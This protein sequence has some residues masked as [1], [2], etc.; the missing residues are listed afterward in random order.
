MKRNYLIY[1]LTITFLGSCAT[2]RTTTIVSCDYDTKLNQTNYMVFPYGAVSLPNKWEKTNY[3]SSARQQFFK[4]EEGVTIAISFAPSNKYE[5][6][7]DNSK[8]GFVFV[9]AFYEWDSQYFVNTF[10][11][12]QDLVEENET[13]NYI[14]WRVYGEYNNSQWDTYFLFGE[15][16]GIAHNY[17][18]TKSDKWTTEQKMKFLKGIYLDQKNK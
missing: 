10:G 8:K 2:Q 16:N 9:K 18:I 6:N 12:E 17:S 11:L 7:T 3:N 4:N 14:I 13:D 1:L 15:K 5:F